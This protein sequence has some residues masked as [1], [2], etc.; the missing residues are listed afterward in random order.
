MKEHKH[1]GVRKQPLAWALFYLRGCFRVQRNFFSYLWNLETLIL[2]ANL[3]KDQ[4][5]SAICEFPMP[6]R[7]WKKKSVELWGSVSIY[8]GQK[9]LKNRHE[10]L[11]FESEHILLR[12]GRKWCALSSLEG[13]WAKAQIMEIWHF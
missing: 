7:A 4:L 11:G 6:L 12:K 10:R 5:I 13:H 3:R 1:K 8:R 2:L 9:T